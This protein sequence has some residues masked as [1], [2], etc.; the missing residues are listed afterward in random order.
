MKFLDLAKVYIKSGA[1]G[2][3]CISFRREAHTEYGGPDRG[4]PTGRVAKEGAR[5]EGARASGRIVR[6]Q[7]ETHRSSCLLQ[8][9]CHVTLPRFV[10]LTSLGLPQ[11]PAVLQQSG[12]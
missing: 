8:N 7:V 9:R 1:G 4:E 6:A 12:F 3:G 10:V 11:D 2:N 5:K